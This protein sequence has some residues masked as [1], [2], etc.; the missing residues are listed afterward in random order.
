MEM[1][2]KFKRPSDL[3]DLPRET[4]PNRTSSQSSSI[5]NSGFK[6]S[7]FDCYSDDST[8]SLSSPPD[9]IDL[10]DSS[11]HHS[12]QSSRPL[13]PY[14]VRPTSPACTT[15]VC[16]ICEAPVD[17]HFLETFGRGGKR[18]RSKEQLDFCRAHKQ[19]TANS[20][21]TSRNYPTIDWLNFDS[22]LARYHADLEAIFDTRTESTYRKELEKQIAT[23]E[24]R[25]D[26]RNYHAPGEHNQVPGYYGLRGKS[27]MLE[28]IMH[29]FGVKIKGLAV[30]DSV[31]A[32]M[33]PSGYVQAVLVP[34]LAVRLI[35]EDMDVKED[36]AREI[37]KESEE[38][39]GLVNVEEEE[40]VIVK[41]EEGNIS[42]NG[43]NGM[44]ETQ[45]NDYWHEDDDGV[46]VLG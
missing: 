17:W 2:T 21:W 22:R 23:G 7:S 46:V 27:R 32:S 25:N 39:G 35:M 8:S 41:D 20:L 15:A 33:G 31:M 4:T 6:T 26:L 13:P 44:Q 34:E 45:E 37:V 5:S 29:E 36:R 9:S 40:R 24:N 11:E 42:E 14:K 10:D 30:T 1:R 43:D 16:P 18:L 12:F 38:V 19:R 3:S 28:Y